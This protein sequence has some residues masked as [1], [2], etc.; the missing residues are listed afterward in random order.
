LALTFYLTQNIGLAPFAIWIAFLFGSMLTPTLCLDFLFDTDADSWF[1]TNYWT[2]G[3]GATMPTLALTPTLG[4]DF[5][6]DSDTICWFGMDDVNSWINASSW[7][8]AG[9][10]P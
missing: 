5:S 4:P 7:V 3:V 10:W 6:F 1:G 9:S 8:D 2:I